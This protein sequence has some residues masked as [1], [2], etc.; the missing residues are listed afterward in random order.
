VRSPPSIFRLFGS[1]LYDIIAL[2]AIWF[3]AALIVVIVRHGEAVNSGNVFFMTYLL[4]VA[5]A[6]FGW[7]WT[8]N[9]QTLGMKSWK[10]R[11]VATETEQTVGWKCAA[12]RCIAALVSFSALG[13][14]FFWAVFDPDSRTWH[15]R[16]SRSHLEKE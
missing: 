3:F 13:L 5:Y 12:I 8:R 10:I 2:A 4:A 1:I 16:I 15:D 7:C 14:G 11:L 6:Y 9:G